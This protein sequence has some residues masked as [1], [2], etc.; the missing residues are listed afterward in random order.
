MV[1]AVFC[2]YLF[3]WLLIWSMLRICMNYTRKQIVL[4]KLLDGEFLSSLILKKVL[5]M[6]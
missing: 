1:N 3:R 2:H 6:H 5:N 4:P